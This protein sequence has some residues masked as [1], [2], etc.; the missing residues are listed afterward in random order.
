N[1]QAANA[2]LKVLEEPPKQAVLILVSHAPGRLLPTIRSRCQRLALKPLS[3]EEVRT[4]LAEQGLAT[5]AGDEELLDVLAGGSPGR[6]S[7][8]IE[9][10]GLDIYRS[11][12]GLLETL[13]QLDVGAL[14]KFADTL[15]QRGA[16]DRFRLFIELWDGMLKRLVKAAVADEGGSAFGNEVEGALF[17]RLVARASLD[18]WM[19]L[20]ENTTRLLGRA[21]A[22]NLDRKH[23]CLIV[24]TQLQKLVR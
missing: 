13:P 6:V 3:P 16:E 9:K 7:D 17:D 12:T 19:E 1:R 2:L 20:W 22:V 8:L 24:F 15:N 4:V 5:G 11:M 23:V 14:H 21:T 18:Q 10:G